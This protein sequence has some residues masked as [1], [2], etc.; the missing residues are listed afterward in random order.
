ME[1]ANEQYSVTILTESEPS[2]EGHPIVHIRDNLDT[3]DF[4]FARLI[5]VESA[6]RITYQCALVDLVVSSAVP[7]AVLEDHVLTVLLFRT[8]LQIDL[9]T[10]AILRC[11]DC[12]NMGGLEEIYS[13]DGGYLIKGEGEI[14]R[15][16]QALRQV[17]WFCG[18]DIFAR[19]TAEK[20]FWIENNLIHCRD[21]EGWHYVLDMDRNLISET[22]EC[23]SGN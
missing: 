7:H 1:L 11:V 9:N 6:G 21:W 2:L 23:V 5:K 19:P 16:D 12:E 4:Y 14:F 3:K 15:Y 20:C 10:K 18:R 8:I 13:I 22:K 17:W